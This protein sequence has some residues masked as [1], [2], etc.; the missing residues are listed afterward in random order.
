MQPA[1]A[2]CIEGLALMV[3][4]SMQS[5]HAGTSHLESHEG[6][7]TPAAA[8]EQIEKVQGR[9]CNEQMLHIEQHCKAECRSNIPTLIHESD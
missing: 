9:Q 7:N 6:L 1:E 8:S 2:L 4:I 5:E 3:C